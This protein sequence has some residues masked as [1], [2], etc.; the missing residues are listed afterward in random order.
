MVLSG[1]CQTNLIGVVSVVH[2]QQNRPWAEQE[3]VFV[4]VRDDGVSSSAHSLICPAFSLIID[5]FLV[6]VQT[7][8]TGCQC[9]EEKIEK[10][11]REC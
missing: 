3:A 7:F 6:V 10:E 11:Q 8:S 9:K 4:R 1:T 2:P 5:H